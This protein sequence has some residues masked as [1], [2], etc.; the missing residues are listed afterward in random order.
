MPDFSRLAIEV[1]EV[2]LPSPWVDLSRWAEGLE[3]FG[4]GAART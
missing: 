1:P 3:F 2:L 4:V